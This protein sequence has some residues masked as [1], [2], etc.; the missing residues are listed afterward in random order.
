MFLLQWW[1][2]EGESFEKH[3]ERWQ[4]R[5]FDRLGHDIGEIP[6]QPDPRLEHLVDEAL[7]G[8]DVAGHDLHQVVEPAAQRP[9]GRDLAILLY[10]VLEGAET[11][12]GMVVQFDGHEDRDMRPKFLEADAGV[13]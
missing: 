10:P 5:G 13:V 3:L 8:V 7:I 4:A 2:P 12:R 11:G 1:P 9:A 6:C